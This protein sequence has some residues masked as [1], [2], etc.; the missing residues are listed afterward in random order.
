[1]F[2]AFVDWVVVKLATVAAP[3]PTEEDMDIQLRK[4]FEPEV[5]YER[6][7]TVD[8]PIREAI[9]GTGFVVLHCLPSAHERTH[10]AGPRTQGRV[11]I[12]GGD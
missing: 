11:E 9:Q 4:M 12:L 1:M 5:F 8:F 2:H 7:K 3:T 10:T 6:A